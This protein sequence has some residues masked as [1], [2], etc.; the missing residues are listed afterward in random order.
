MIE[1]HFYEAPEADCL[2]VAIEKRFLTDSDD[3][4]STI[5]DQADVTRPGDDVWGW[6]DKN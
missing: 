5:N 3:G 6:M 2:N 4:T 1:K